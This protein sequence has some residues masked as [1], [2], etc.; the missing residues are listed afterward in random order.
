MPRWQL[1][2]P[3]KNSH[4]C[5]NSRNL[6]F[7]VFKTYT[8]Q[9]NKLVGTDLKLCFFQKSH[10]RP[11][12]YFSFPWL[13]KEIFRIHKKLAILSYLCSWRLL[14]KLCFGGSLNLRGHGLGLQ[15]AGSG[16][17]F[18]ETCGQDVVKWFLSLFLHFW[19]S[20]YPSLQCTVN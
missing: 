9:Q 1:T 19:I 10:P 17:A 20:Y 8:T 7:P 5:I 12:S 13:I 14:E 6:I 15:K 16:E 18:R 11:P 3:N 2:E 4:F